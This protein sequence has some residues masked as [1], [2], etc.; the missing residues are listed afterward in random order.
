MSALLQ[1]SLAQVVEIAFFQGLILYRH[2]FLLGLQ[3]ELRADPQNLHRVSSCLL[4]APQFTIGKGLPNVRPHNVRV[5]YEV[6]LEDGYRVR[7]FAP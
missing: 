1:P 2:P 6:R 3:G 7:I 4:L 5:Q